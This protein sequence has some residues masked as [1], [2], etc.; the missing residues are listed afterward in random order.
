VSDQFLLG[1]ALMVSPV[2]QYQ[3]RSRSV[4]LP[5]SGWY[6]LWTGAAIAGGQRVTAPAPYDAIP[7]HVRSGSILPLGPELAYTG[8]KPSDPIVLYVYAGADGSFSLYEDDGL[9]YGYERG[10]L[11]RIPIT[12]VDATHTLTL[13]ERQGSFPGMLAERRFDVVL[14]S[15]Q[16]PVGFSFAPNAQRSLAY[17]GGAVQATF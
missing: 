6:D 10:E 15:A 13:G 11:S 17:S 12:W 2:T 3:A 16:T 8:E 4:Y 1:P 14:V 9:T 5:A 7:V